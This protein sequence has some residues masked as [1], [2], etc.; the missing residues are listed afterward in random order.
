M[1]VASTDLKADFHSSGFAGAEV[2]CN[3]R[4]KKVNCFENDGTFFLVHAA[5]NGNDEE[6]FWRRVICS[7][8][9]HRSNYVPNV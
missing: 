1:V 8:E 2:H 5:G 3:N 4:W 9:Y 7:R 6:I